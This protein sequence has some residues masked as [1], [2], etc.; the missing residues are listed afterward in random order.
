MERTQLITK[1]FRAFSGAGGDANKTSLCHHSLFSYILLHRCFGRIVFSSLKNTRLPTS[2]IP[3]S[4][5]KPITFSLPNS[6][7]LD[8]GISHTRI[9][10]VGRGGCVGIS[11]KAFLRRNVFPSNACVGGICFVFGQPALPGACPFVLIMHC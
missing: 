9:F 7:I 6:R 2:D 8:L 10:K 4:V 5:V 11:Q 3:V 1:H